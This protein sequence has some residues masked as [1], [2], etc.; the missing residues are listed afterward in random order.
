MTEASGFAAF[1]L[2]NAL[3][4][5]FTSNSYNYFKYNGKTN[6]SKNSFMNRKDKFTFYRLSR[7][8]DLEELKYYMVANFLKDNGNWVGDMAGPEAEEHYKKWQKINQSLTYTFEND[9]MFLLD[10]V[11][12]PNEMLEVKNNSFPKLMM[13]VM[14]GSVTLETLVILNDILNFFPMWDKKIYDDLVYPNFKLKCEKY[15]PF[16]QYDKSKFKDILKQK[17]MD[18]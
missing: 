17:I 6:V 8:F 16:L 2:W 10:R 18:K 5:H 7:K 9:I 12:N 13:F 15:A 11:E 14:E 1:A 4:L 3:K